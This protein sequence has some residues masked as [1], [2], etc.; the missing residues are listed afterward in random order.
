MIAE[1]TARAREA[2]EQFLRD[3]HSSLGGIRQVGHG[4]VE[5]LPRDQGRGVTEGS[6]DQQSGSRGF[7][8]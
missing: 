4:V 1:V 2:A 3:S 8:S 5:I 6:Q 7:H